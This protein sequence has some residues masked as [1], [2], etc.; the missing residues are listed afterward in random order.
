MP[1]DEH[2]VFQSSV[3]NW[4]KMNPK[5]ENDSYLETDFTKTR[6]G[7][8]IFRIEPKPHYLQTFQKLILRINTLYVCIC[9]TNKRLLKLNSNKFTIIRNT[10]VHTKLH[11]FAN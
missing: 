1:N 5:E 9:P 10:Y 7:W 2:K 11:A 4:K 6:S 3:K 8:L